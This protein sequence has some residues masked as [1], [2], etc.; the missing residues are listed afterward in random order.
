MQ[1]FQEFPVFWLGESFEG[2]PL[3]SV[4]RYVYPGTPGIGFDDSEDLVSFSYGDCFVPE[5]VDTGCPVPLTIET[6]P[7]CKVPPSQLADAVKVGPPF[8][9]RGALAQ[10][11]GPGS[12][13]L[14]TR[15]VTIGIYATNPD[16]VLKAAEAM[17]RINGGIPTRSSEDLGPPDPTIVCPPKSL[18]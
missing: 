10:R 15:T 12:L 6:M 13:R 4:I 8:T 16:H 3:T 17:V 9:I 7:Y 11:T 2:L 14:W 5:G 1:Q 18:Q